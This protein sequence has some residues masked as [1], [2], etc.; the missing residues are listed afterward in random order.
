M[1]ILNILT[2]LNEY[3]SFIPSVQQQ[4][5]QPVVEDLCSFIKNEYWNNNVKMQ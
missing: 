2:Q 5:L 3:L 4:V 1:R